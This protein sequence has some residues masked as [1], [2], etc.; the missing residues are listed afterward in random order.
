V[1]RLAFLSFFHLPLKIKG[2][3]AA[4]GRTYRFPE[5]AKLYQTKPED[6]IHLVK[7]TAR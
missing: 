4:G 1:Y 7:L 5:S 6:L 2:L 3:I